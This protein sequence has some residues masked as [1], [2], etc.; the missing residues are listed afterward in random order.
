MPDLLPSLTSG[1]HPVPLPPSLKN[2]QVRLWLGMSL[3]TPLYFGLVS[4]VH[5]TA[6]HFIIQD[7]AR[8]HLVWLQRLIHPD[9]FPADLIAS[10]YTAIQPAG[11]KAFYSGVAFLGIAPLPFAKLVPIGLALIT[12][13]YLFRVALLL[14]PIPLSGFLTTL[15]LNQ[16]VWLKDDLISATPRAFIYP[17]FAAFLYYLLRGATLPC[18]LTLG[19]QGLFYPQMMLVS[20]GILTLRL[21]Q[22][23][24][25]SLQFSQ[26]WKD[27][28]VWLV[29]MGL[30]AGMLALFSHQVLEQVGRLVTLDE[31]QTMPE[32]QLNGRRQ[33]FGVSPWQFVFGGASGLRFPLFPPMIGIGILLPLVNWKSRSALSTYITRHVEV[34]K[35]LF[36]AALGLFLLAH[37]VFPSLYLPSRYTFYSFRFLLVLA[38]G[39]VLTLLA[40]RVWCWLKLHWQSP[41]PTRWERVKVFFVV[42]LASA[43][44]LVPAIPALFLPCQGWVMGATPG[45]YKLLAQSPSNSLVATLTPAANNVPAFAHRSV[46]V[47]EELA[48]PYHVNFYNVMLQ[49]MRDLVQ[50]Q[51]SPDRATLQSFIETSGIDLWIIDQNFADPDY[52]AQQSWLI[53]SSMRETVTA[54]MRN[55]QQG[56]QPALVQMMSSCSLLTEENLNLLDARCISRMAHELPQAKLK[57]S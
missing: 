34:L 22:W 52:L 5:A 14:L 6:S 19:L 47:A 26:R 57:L 32:F 28:G 38:S 37:L 21:V 27:Y 48:L 23:Q 20:V 16:N 1:F 39:I 8:L 41:V 45:I 30:T 13:V 56:M 31:M 35:Q 4:W 36:L 7:D 33:Y 12:T 55:L 3:L 44:V 53:N 54:T 43:I 40:E 18:L 24:G 17:I 42:L 10:Y 11:F 29:A 46:F 51:Y 9:L 2:P 50:A 15:L 25:S 49:R